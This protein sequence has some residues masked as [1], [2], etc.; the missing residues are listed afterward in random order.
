MGAN[1][2]RRVGCVPGEIR[3]EMTEMNPYPAGPAGTEGTA[4]PAC[5]ARLPAANNWNPPDPAPHP[6]PTLAGALQ[7]AENGALY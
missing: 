4:G 6:M 2:G 7:E 1:G 3:W 5:L